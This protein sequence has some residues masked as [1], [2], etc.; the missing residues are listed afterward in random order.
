MEVMLAIDAVVRF[1]RASVA[2]P[3]VLLVILPFE[4][5]EFCNNVSIGFDVFDSVQ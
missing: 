5:V 1:A 3:I 4:P 2:F